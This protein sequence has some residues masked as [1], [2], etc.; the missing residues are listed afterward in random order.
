MS[1]SIFIYGKPGTGKRTLAL[2][3]TISQ[4]R[5]WFNSAKDSF[6]NTEIAKI[7]TMLAIDP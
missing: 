7:H 3:V 6:S 2:T 1:N 5:N 4:K